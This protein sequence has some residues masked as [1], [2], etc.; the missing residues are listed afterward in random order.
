M[1][2]SNKTIGRALLIQN[3][4]RWL[5]FKDDESANRALDV[6]YIF[7]KKHLKYNWF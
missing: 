4:E 3:T 1:L 5:H 6:L 7:Y 2:E